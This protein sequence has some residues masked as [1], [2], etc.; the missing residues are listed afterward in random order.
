MKIIPESRL[1]AL[2]IIADRIDT[3][4]VLNLVDELD[5]PQSVSGDTQLRLVP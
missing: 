5:V 3:E 4:R 1:N 2:I